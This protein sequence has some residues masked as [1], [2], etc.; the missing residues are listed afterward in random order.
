MESKIAKWKRENGLT[1]TAYELMTEAFRVFIENNEYG[2]INPPLE[3]YLDGLL[4][5]ISA[6]TDLDVEEM[7]QEFET[8]LPKKDSDDRG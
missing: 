6:Q 5:G 7:R 4:D 1:D 8:W 3:H 2:L